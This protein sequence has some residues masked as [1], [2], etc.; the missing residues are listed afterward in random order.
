[1]HLHARPVWPSPGALQKG[2]TGWAI[3][4]EVSGAMEGCFGR[5]KGIE[6]K[7]GEKA[8]FGSK[9]LVG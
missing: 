3:R 6:T 5:E 9:A 4:P 1:M 8:S 2:L 7:L